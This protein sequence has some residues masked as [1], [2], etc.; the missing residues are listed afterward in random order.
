[1]IKIK[2]E[3]EE[4]LFAAVKKSKENT[5]ILNRVIEAFDA[6]TFEIAALP[7]IGHY[8][9]VVDFLESLDIKESDYEFIY[10]YVNHLQVIS[11][12]SVKREYFVISTNP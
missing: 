4:E 10:D 8:I 12:I 6:N 9:D 5:N 1:M 2:I 3:C 7:R 11:S